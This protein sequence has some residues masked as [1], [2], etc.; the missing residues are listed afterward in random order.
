MTLDDPIDTLARTIYAEARSGGANAMA[1]VAS[2]VLNRARFPRWWGSTILTVCRAPWQF[3][4]WNP[5]TLGLPPDSNY[6]AM[7]RAT[8]ADPVF[9]IALDIARRAVAGS[10]RDETG[11]ADSYF[12]LTIAPPAWTRGATH[13][14]GDGW[15]SFWITRHCAHAPNAYKP[16]P[17]PKPETDER[18][19]VGNAGVPP[20][21]PGSSDADAL[22][23][24][25][26]D[27]LDA[28]A[29]AKET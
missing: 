21:G 9:T 12:A 22:N 18:H 7:I 20:N 28:A 4:C 15:H 24:A 16:C 19:P 2:V 13:T 8:D 10:L 6:E 25:E 29:A 23:G 3:S 1:H 26:L 17:G 5:Y 14:V 11:S 27:Q